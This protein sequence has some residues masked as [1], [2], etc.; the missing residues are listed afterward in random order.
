VAG[1]PTRF[2]N[3]LRFLD[4]L[5]AVASFRKQPPLG[6]P[7]SEAPISADNERVLIYRYLELDQQPPVLGSQRD[8]A[9]PSLRPALK[10]SALAGPELAFPAQMQ[11]RKGRH[12][13][14]RDHSDPAAFP[15]NDS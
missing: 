3:I 1:R 11:V 5:G 10:K 7:Q 8:R 6:Y 15:E 14:L 9:F 13:E 12:A 2:S 4:S